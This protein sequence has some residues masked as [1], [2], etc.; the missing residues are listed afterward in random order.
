MYVRASFV[1]CLKKG[2]RRDIE[3]AGSA[4]M[5]NIPYIPWKYLLQ[6]KH[7][8]TFWFDSDTE[9]SFSKS[10]SRRVLP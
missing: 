5:H 4:I 3:K 7:A 1:L 9:Q 2:K 8:Y 10:K 6:T